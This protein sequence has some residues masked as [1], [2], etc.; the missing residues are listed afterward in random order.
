MSK[1]D[2]I[3]KLQSAVMRLADTISDEDARIALVLAWQ[4]IRVAWYLVRGDQDDAKSKWE[5]LQ[6]EIEY[7]NYRFK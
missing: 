4:C 7:L 1:L 6:S 2:E 3:Q 5:Y